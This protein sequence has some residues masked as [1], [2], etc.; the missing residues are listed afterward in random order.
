MIK[1]RIL[2][3][4]FLSLSLSHAETAENFGGIGITIQST[5]P[6]V[7]V[8]DVVPQSPAWQAGLQS[9]DLL[10]QVNG[11][12]LRDVSTDAARDLLRGQVG[13]TLKLS[14]QQHQSQA[15]LQLTLERVP[16][17]VEALQGSQVAAY[18]GDNNQ[19]PLRTTDLMY[20]ATSRLAEGYR[21]AS[22]MA[23]GKSVQQKETISASAHITAVALGIAQP[24]VTPQALIPQIEL[25]TY[26]RKFLQIHLQKSGLT[27]IRVL[28][29][30][31]RTVFS[32]TLSN[33]QGLLQLPWN[34]AELP[35]GHY[36]LR[37]RQGS[38]H[39]TWAINLQ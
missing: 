13:S 2:L 10:L 12:T 5:G 27:E 11:T 9:G 32:N 30:Q 36:T 14:V 20:Y 38:S 29:R 7:L 39:A 19:K 37:S 24:A 6:G 33:A 31:G 8:V 18:F 34:G 3:A 25:R 16:I 1:S 4:F 23:D 28:D 17:S 26:D 15:M 35:S 22:V 21:L